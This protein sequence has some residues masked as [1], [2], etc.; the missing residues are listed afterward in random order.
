MTKV[1]QR[2]GFK[3]SPFNS[4]SVF[5]AGIECEIEG[6]HPE[7]CV[8]AKPELRTSAYEGFGIIADGSLRN[9]GAEFVSKVFTR[10]ILVEHFKALQEELSFVDRDNAFSS[11]TSTHVHVNV[12]SL[13]E[14]QAKN[15]LLLY[16]LYEDF[17]FML[18]D[19]TRRGNIH[20]VPLTETYLPNRYMLPLMDLAHSWHK[21]T[22]LNVV[23]MFKLGSFEFRHLQGTGDAVLLNE[24]LTVLE[25]LWLV[26]Q[27]ITVNKGFLQSAAAIE[28]TFERIFGQSAKIMAVKNSLFNVI[29]NT[30]LDVKF[31]FVV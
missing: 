30:L 8:L 10:P 11:R 13:E 16:S 29:R 31:A 1:Y 24:W 18:V 6:L 5:L 26:S 17:F 9:N 2:V 7:I 23:P 21:Y 12:R 15:M 19:S 4:A 14:E 27:E 3:E 25:N 22:A 20:C 28:G